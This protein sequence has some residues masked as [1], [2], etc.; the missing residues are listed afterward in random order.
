MKKM[1]QKLFTLM[2]VTATLST[3]Q[4][5][6]HNLS[7]WPS[8][9]TVNSSKPTVLT[10]DFTRGDLAYRLGKAVSPIGFNVLDPHG[11][12][13]SLSK[14]PYQGAERTTVEL[15]INEQGTYTL[16]YDTKPR[17]TT[18]YTAGKEAKKKRLRLDKIAAKEELPNSAK[19]V[20][21]KKSIT[22]AIAFITNIRPSSE[23]FE[24]T[25][26]GLEI[27]LMTHPS[28]YVTEETIAMLVTY[29][30]KPFTN[31]EVSLTRDGAQYTVNSAPTRSITD[32]NGE[33]NF[34]FK[35]GGRYML[36]IKH[37]VKENTELYDELSHRLFYAFEVIY[38]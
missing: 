6:A 27:T 20:M 28:D 4:A 29:N 36:S 25:G 1:T 10:I 26:K 19:H 17:Y 38:E 11:K 18:S 22:S 15:P 32:K 13:I 24:I 31:G 21:T 3:M 37:S 2:V 8:K 30:G 7:M 5:S 12:V 9:F 16:K 33:L 34:I 35:Q 23:S 14:A